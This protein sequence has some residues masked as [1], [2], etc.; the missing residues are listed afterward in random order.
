MV[1][2]ELDFDFGPVSLSHPI[3][4]QHAGSH[5]ASAVQNDDPTQAIEALIDRIRAA[6]N[7]SAIV[8]R[9][10]LTPEASAVYWRGA[11]QTTSSG[12]KRP[13]GSWAT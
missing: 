12:R 1:R 7:P 3:R 13:R 10:G 4:R 6:R 11:K 8:P 5:A 9:S 2:I